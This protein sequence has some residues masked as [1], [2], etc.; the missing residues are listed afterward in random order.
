MPPF[1]P[2]RMTVKAS[3]GND[4]KIPDS[5]G[6]CGASPCA[7]SCAAGTGLSYQLSSASKSIPLLSRSSRIGSASTSRKRSLQDNGIT[8]QQGG[9]LQTAGISGGGLESAAPCLRRAFGL[10]AAR[11]HSGVSSLRELGLEFNEQ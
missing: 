10:S 5:L 11:F 2:A 6:F 8:K 1:F 7:V 3:G 4:A 9:G